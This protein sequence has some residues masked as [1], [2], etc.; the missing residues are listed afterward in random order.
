M[1]FHYFQ[2]SLPFVHRVARAIQVLSHDS[3]ATSMHFL[4][5]YGLHMTNYLHHPL[6]LKVQSMED[7]FND[8]T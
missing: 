1:T 2:I 5:N 4:L 6:V 8:T 3:N 7:F